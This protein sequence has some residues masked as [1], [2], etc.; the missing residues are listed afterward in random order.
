MKELKVRLKSKEIKNLHA[1]KGGDD[2]GT[3]KKRKMKKPRKHR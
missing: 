3:I 1:V 2:E